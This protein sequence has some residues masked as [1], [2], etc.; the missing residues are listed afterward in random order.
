MEIAEQERE[1]MHIGNK[2]LNLEE[3]ETYHRQTYGRTRPVNGHVIDNG[4]GGW[5]LMR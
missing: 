1:L 3:K 2:R 5:R 4:T